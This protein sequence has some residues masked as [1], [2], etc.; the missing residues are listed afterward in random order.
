MLAVC[1]GAGQVCGTGE[2]PQPEGVDE[3]ASAHYADGAAH[4]GSQ[5]ALEGAQRD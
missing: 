2:D 3:R 5:G 4:Q 1:E